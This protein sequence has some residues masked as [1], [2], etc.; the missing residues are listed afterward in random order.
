MS[1][2]PTPRFGYGAYVRI[3]PLDLIPAR[4][5]DLHFFGMTSTV[6]YDIRYFHDGREFKIRVFEDEIEPME[7]ERG[8]V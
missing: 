4:V 3:K 6:E 8:R 5:V 7:A 2:W 1:N